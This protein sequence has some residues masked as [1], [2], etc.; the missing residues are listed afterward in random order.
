MSLVTSS[1][2]NLCAL[3]IICDFI[4]AAHSRKVDLWIS[5]R[6]SAFYPHSAVQSDRRGYGRKR[7]CE[8]KAADA[9]RPH[10][11]ISGHALL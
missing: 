5:S 2:F 4:D 11:D 3:L 7:N 8:R 6:G 1:T 10:A 9:R